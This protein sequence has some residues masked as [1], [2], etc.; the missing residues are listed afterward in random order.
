MKQLNSRAVKENKSK[1]IFFGKTNIISTSSLILET[2]ECV[3]KNFV[4]EKGYSVYFLLLFM[5]S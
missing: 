3:A 1:V 2:C 5:L 4:L